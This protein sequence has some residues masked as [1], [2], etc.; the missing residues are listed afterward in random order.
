METEE[1]IERLLRLMDQL[2]D[3]SAPDTS[4]DIWAPSEAGLP[5]ALVDSAMDGIDE[6]FA[7]HDPQLL[8]RLVREREPKDP[9]PQQVDPRRLQ[10]ILFRS[11]REKK[12]DE[13]QRRLREKNE[14]ILKTIAGM[15]P[16]K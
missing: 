13:D 5:G 4:A 10:T 16:Q 15:G 12:Y 14:E 2:P 8:E 3:T 9:P 7:E 1:T 11:E 6:D